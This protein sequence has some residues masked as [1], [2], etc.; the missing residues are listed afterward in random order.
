MRLTPTVLPPAGRS[1]RVL[2][3]HGFAG[4]AYFRWPAVAR[5]PI[6]TSANPGLSHKHRL[7]LYSIHA[8]TRPTILYLTC[9]LYFI[10]CLYIPIFYIHKYWTYPHSHISLLYSTTT[11]WCTWLNYSWLLSQSYVCFT[12]KHAYIIIDT[13]SLIAYISY[14][15]LT[16]FWSPHWHKLPGGPH[17]NPTVFCR[18]YK[19]LI[20]HLVI[21]YSFIHYIYYGCHI[22][23]PVIYRTLPIHLFSK[24][25]SF[26]I[27]FF[28]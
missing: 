22:I 24:L 18:L 2:I 7:G 26:L 12:N 28:Y 17:I 15:C 5:Y 3:R 20:T 11:C 13:I 25:A 10:F 23:S 6:R 21:F 9:S 19:Y 4:W 27:S 14:F 8:L 16:L 1:S